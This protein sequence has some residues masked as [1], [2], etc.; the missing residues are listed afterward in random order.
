MEEQQVTINQRIG[1]VIDH[2]E[3]GSQASFARKVGI[4]TGSIGDIM[5]KRQAKPGYDILTKIVAAYPEL[6][7]DWLL[8]GRGEMLHAAP[9]V[10]MEPPLVLQFDQSEVDA[11]FLEEV[12]RLRT[13]GA[14]N[15]FT[16]LAQKLQAH[17][18]IISDIEAGR[19]HCNLKLLYM[20][21]A[22]YDVDLLYIIRSD[23]SPSRPLIL[24]PDVTAGRPPKAATPSLTATLAQA[25]TS[26]RRRKRQELMKN[27]PHWR[28]M[29]FNYIGDT[30]HPEVKSDS[31]LRQLAENVLPLYEND[32][33]PV[34]NK[35]EYFQMIVREAREYAATLPEE[36]IYVKDVK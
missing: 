35:E 24:K 17:R 3:K 25:R 13:E 18:S 16:E 4:R 7:A 14:F 30:Y 2:F 11:R 22:C 10:M 20:L 29:L 6:R 27:E 9:T 31:Y 34:T 1:Q 32:N 12:Y 15:T 5:G 36:S 28:Q 23:G 8:I 21:D 33:G 26:E 19:Y